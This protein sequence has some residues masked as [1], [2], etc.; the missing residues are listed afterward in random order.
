MSGTMYLDSQGLPEGI[1]N[2]ISRGLENLPDY[3]PLF[4]AAYVFELQEVEKRMEA[5]G[6]VIEVDQDSTD[7][8]QALEA[9]W[10]R[11]LELTGLLWPSSVSNPDAP[12]PALPSCGMRRVPS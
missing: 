7:V 12:M 5:L 8:V 10:R 1:E 4:R 2:A 11:R 3:T 9:L 6:D